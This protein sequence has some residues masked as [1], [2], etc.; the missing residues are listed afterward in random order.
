M[1]EPTAVVF[2]DFIVELAK[3][4]NINI[5]SKEPGQVTI[6][7]TL[8]NGRH[9]RVWIKPFL[10]DNLKHL[11]LFAIHSPALT[12]PKGQQLGKETA[13]MILRR[14]STLPQGAWAIEEGKNEDYL[15]VM[16][17]LIANYVSPQE[18]LEAVEWAAI[19]AD[20]MEKTFGQDNF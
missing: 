9:Q 2:E 8:D 14:N 6:N 19:L 13:N 1:A 7:Y 3:K 5:A 18:F 15:V 11:L 16:H 17:V 12:M 20:D 10:N 4:A